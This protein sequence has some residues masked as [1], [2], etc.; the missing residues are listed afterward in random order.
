MSYTVE[1]EFDCL[2]LSEALPGL[3]P[4]LEPAGNCVRLMIMPTGPGGGN[5]CMVVRWVVP[6]RA[7]LAPLLASRR[8]AARVR[9]WLAKRWMS[10]LEDVGTDDDTHDYAGG[11]DDH[12]HEFIEGGS[13]PGCEALAGAAD[14][15]GGWIC[16]RCGTITSSGVEVCWECSDGRAAPLA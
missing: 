9:A 7:G 1:I 10:W 8:S 11:L 14:D 16:R 15:D 5:P 3:L 12:E 6:N 13:C 2:E 4:L